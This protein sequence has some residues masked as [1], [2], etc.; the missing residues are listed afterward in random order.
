VDKSH[1]YA[2]RHAD[3]GTP[4]EVLA[5]LMGH[6]RLT[7]TQVYYRNPRVLHHPGEKALV[8]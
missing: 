1:S 7:S 5:E 4:I 3:A 8:A 2:Q 6:T